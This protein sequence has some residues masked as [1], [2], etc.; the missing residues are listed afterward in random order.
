M[1]VISTTDDQFFDWV[2]MVD[3]KVDK[4]KLSVDSDADS[5]A[6]TSVGDPWSRQT[7]DTS[8]AS[9]S[10][11][12]GYHDDRKEG[13]YVDSLDLSTAETSTQEDIDSDSEMR[14]S[15]GLSEQN[16]FLDLDD[17]FAID[18]PKHEASEYSTIEL[19]ASLAI[20]DLKNAAMD[21]HVFSPALDVAIAQQEAAEKEQ[22]P[23]MENHVLSVARDTIKPK[24]RAAQLRA[25]WEQMQ[26]RQRDHPPPK[27]AFDANKQKVLELADDL[28]EAFGQDVFQLRLHRFL[29][30]ARSK[31]NL[32][33]KAPLG[34][35]QGRQDLVSSVHSKIL[36]TY[37]Y[38]SYGSELGY[39]SMLLAIEPYCFDRD[40]VGRLHTT[41][42]F[43]GLPPNST[44]YDVLDTAEK[45]LPVIG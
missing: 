27:K 18:V 1:E 6:A 3:R 42:A 37:G 26:Q 2:S 9:K 36:P 8:S 33:P 31:Q 44:I 40:V 15:G 23:G 21:G 14:L 30:E 41:D 34:F 12:F 4:A 38:G 20:E 17:I 10:P 43:L 13:I 25:K 7:S 22:I 24:D 16:E 5:S 32:P 39:Y 35:V 28:N 19:E 29:R 45:F 11:P